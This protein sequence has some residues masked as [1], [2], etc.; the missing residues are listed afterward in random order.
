MDLAICTIEKANSLVNKLI[1]EKRYFDVEFIIIDELHMVQDQQR[2]FLLETIII[3]LNTI[4][5]MF[6]QVNRFQIVAMSA[7]INGLHL[8][9]KWLKTAEIYQSEYRPVPL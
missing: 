8:L 4:Q 3:K 2:G 1:E 7:T 9:K 5:K 6:N